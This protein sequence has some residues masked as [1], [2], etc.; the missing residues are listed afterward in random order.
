MTG[1]PQDRRL[2][3][4]AADTRGRFSRLLGATR[5]ALLLPHHA[6]HPNAFA[7]CANSITRSPRMS[8]G[9]IGSMASPSS[10]IC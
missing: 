3:P 2:E 10:A 9:R 1:V 8:C 6:L 5:L 4:I 7:A